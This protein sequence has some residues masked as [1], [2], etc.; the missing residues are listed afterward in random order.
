M[1]ISKKD[2]LNETGI[3]YGQL[4]RWKREGLIPEEWF[5]KQPSFTGQE[6][7]FPKNQILNRIKSIQE[8]KDKYSLEELAK[9]LSPEIAERYFTIDDLNIIEEI[10]KNLIPAFIKGFEKNNFTFVEV[11]IMI[12]LSEFKEASDISLGQIIDVIQGLQG[13]LPT[14]K[15]TGYIFILFDKDQDYYATMYE[16][17]AQVYLDSRLNIVK[18]IHLNDLSNQLK[19][20]YRKSFNFKFDEEEDRKMNMDT[21]GFEVELT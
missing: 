6:T 14:I 1:L 15:S 10:K 16:E 5:I 7:Y 8:L 12:A 20:K 13:Y 21:D 19:L 9:I 3:S 2:L 11:L 17:Q 4:Y 18:K